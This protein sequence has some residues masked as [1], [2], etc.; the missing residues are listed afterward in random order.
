MLQCTTATNVFRMCRAG[1]IAL[2][3]GGGGGGGCP[4]CGCRYVTAARQLLPG[5][6]PQHL[7][8]QRC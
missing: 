4:G 1:L 5:S 3:G 6:C 8:V 7:P 2:G